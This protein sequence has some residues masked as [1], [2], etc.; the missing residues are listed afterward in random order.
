MTDSADCYGAPLSPARD[1]FEM[2]RMDFG[3]VDFGIETRFGCPTRPRLLKPFLGIEQFQDRG[4][5]SLTM[6]F[7][8]EYP[9]KLGR[10][11]RHR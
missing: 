1:R 4:A 2:T 9:K 7:R 11:T 6:T 3:V 10:L 5:V 8:D